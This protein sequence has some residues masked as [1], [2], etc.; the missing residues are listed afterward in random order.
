MEENNQKSKTKN[1][2]TITFYGGANTVTGSNFMFK[3]DVSGTTILIDC[4]LLQGKKIAADE[5]RKPFAY[6]PTKVDILFITHAHIDH[7]GL[8]PKLVKEG[9]HG[10]IYSTPP[11]REIAEHMLVDSMG[12]LGKEAKR[13]GLP[14]IYDA[15]DVRKAMAL[16]GT[17][18]YHKATDMPGGFQITLL[19]AGH[20]LGSAMVEIV[21]DGRKIVFTGD[22]GNSPAPL[23]RDTEKL[24]GVN[25]LIMESVYGDRNHETRAERKQML[26][27]V[28][29]ETV[30]AGGTL[31]VPAFSLER[32]QIL[33][34]EI[35]DLVDN[36]RIPKVPIFLDSP[37]AIKVTGVY[38]KSAEYFNT[39]A[40]DI[41]TG[42]ED[43]FKFPNL[44]FSMETEESKAIA[45][46]P[47]PKVIIAGS[48]MSNGGRIIH[49]E[50][51]YLPDPKN[52]LLIIGYQAAGTPGRMLADG[53]KNIKILGTEVPVNARIAKIS[54]YSAHKDS[55][56]LVDLVRDTAD[57][58]EKV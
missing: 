15:E 18:P 3:D 46:V 55:D 53:V 48:G 22:L 19:D 31:M 34:F 10:K 39:N 30:L 43:V 11:T 52:T 8:I 32:T 23:L 37:L 33:L 4:G 58:L 47:S 45:G 57:S 42:G 26:E 25:Y 49:H 13:D 6:D 36:G 40:H 21:R 54:G 17:I 12:V 20:I 51:M 2:S 14:V 7:I 9:F 56:G 28:I 41:V 35:K 29:E 27:D 24:K 5:N 50:K 1:T 44:K 16:W 38:K